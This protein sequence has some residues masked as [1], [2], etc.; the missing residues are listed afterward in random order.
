VPPLRVGLDAAACCITEATNLSYSGDG[1]SIVDESLS[2]IPI[3][4]L[5]IIGISLEIASLKD[6]PVDARKFSYLR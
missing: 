1:T 4:L 6:R 2:L 5:K 3:H